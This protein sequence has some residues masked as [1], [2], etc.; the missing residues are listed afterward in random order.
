MAR[1]IDEDKLRDEIDKWLDSV[2]TAYIGRGLSYYGE[3]LGCIEDT[4]TEDVQE[5]KHGYWIKEYLGYNVYRYRC[6]ECS[7]IFGEDMIKEFHHD[8]YCSNCGAKMDKE[9]E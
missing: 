6:S 5:V 4:P 7:N 3:L 1:Y 8:K 9:V 2:G